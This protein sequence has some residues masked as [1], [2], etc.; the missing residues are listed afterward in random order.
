MARRRGTATRRDDFRFLLSIEDLLPRRPHLLLAI[1][2]QFQAF[3]HE[4]LADVLD[5]LHRYLA[6]LGDGFVL[7]GWTML[8]AI[9]QQQ[10]L[11]VSPLL[12]GDLLLRY[13]LRE[14][15]PFVLVELHDIPLV[16][17]SL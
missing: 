4:T 15:F 1:E 11:R 3:E 13:Q 10:H 2:S 6:G 7:P 8:A 9:R 17:G 16:H 12:R 14:F 5:R